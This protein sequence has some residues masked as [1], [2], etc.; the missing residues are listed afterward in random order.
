MSDATC[1]TTP[2][3][4]LRPGSGKQEYPR[5]RLIICCDGT[6][7]TNDIEARSLSNVARITRCISDV[8]DWKSGQDDSKERNYISQI[9]YYQPGVGMGTGQFANAVD[10]VTGRGMQYHQALPEVYHTDMSGYR[11]LQVHQTGIQLHMSQLVQS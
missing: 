9:V 10:A 11:T 1:S 3:K 4:S 8:D 7:Q 6:W 5:K 2:S